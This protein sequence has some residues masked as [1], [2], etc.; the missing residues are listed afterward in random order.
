MSDMGVRFCPTT[1]DI[2]GQ[3]STVAGKEQ[4]WSRRACLRLGLLGGA[5]GLVPRRSAA[6]TIPRSALRPRYWMQVLLGG[7][8]DGLVTVDP[9]KARSVEK[10]VE[11]PYAWNEVKSH[12]NLALGPF[13]RPLLPE[14]GAMAV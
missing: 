14:A 6:S 1:A 7:G 11:V 4:V 13:F 12:G 3:M 5:A 10:W 8:I 2:L 9:K